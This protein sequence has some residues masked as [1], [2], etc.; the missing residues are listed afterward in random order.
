M[1]LRWLAALAF[2][3][4]TGYASPDG[5]AIFSCNDGLRPVIFKIE[6]TGEQAI[7]E[8]IPYGDI[9]LLMSGTAKDYK[10]PHDQPISW[11]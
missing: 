2:T 1:S 7:I 3:M 11:S 5:V 8:Y 9:F 10:L 4:E 6:Q